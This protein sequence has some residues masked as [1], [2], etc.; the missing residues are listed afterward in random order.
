MTH[1]G[2]KRLP[3]ESRLN[4]PQES[5]AS[6]PLTKKDM[7]RKRTFSEIVDLTQ[8]PSDDEDDIRRVKARLGAIN[9]LNDE[10][11]KSS[12]VTSGAVSDE[13]RATSIHP[14]ANKEKRKDR[15]RLLG[16]AD[17][18]GLSSWVATEDE[19][20]DLSRFKY[21]DSQQD[22]I[23]SAIIIRRMD[24]ANNALRRSTY[25]PKTIARDILISAGKHPTLPPLN[26]HLDIL[27]RKFTHVDF[28]SDLSTFRWDLVDPGRQEVAGTEVH[29]VDM[30]DAD[31]EDLGGA[32]A[33]RRGMHVSATV[34]GEERVATAGKIIP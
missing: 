4:Q 27:R 12:T 28:T 31:D 9:N 20:S 1:N 30:N 2:S 15:R 6:T 24:K 14:T 11:A 25:N 5:S 17:Q 8:D 21:A 23:Q 3:D 33:A 34:D 13:A 26:H 29:D 19:N 16:S 7:A 18:S 32:L 10:A 22:L